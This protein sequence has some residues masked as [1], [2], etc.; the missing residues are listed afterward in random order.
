MLIL[1]VWQLYEED[2]LRGMFLKLAYFVFFESLK[3]GKYAYKTP[4]TPYLSIFIIFREVYLVTQGNGNDC[5]RISV[6]IRVALG[7]YISK[8]DLILIFGFHSR[9]RYAYKM[10]KILKFGLFNI[11]RVVY[12]VL[13]SLISANQALNNHLRASY[14]KYTTKTCPS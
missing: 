4:K 13:K 11:F 12:M 5:I 1:Y 3:R 10:A 14:H 7:E 8:V 2:I 6:I 9:G